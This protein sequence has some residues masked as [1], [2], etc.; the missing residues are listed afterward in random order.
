MIF[1]L[2]SSSVPPKETHRQPLTL[3]LIFTSPGARPALCLGKWSAGATSGLTISPLPDSVP[4]RALLAMSTGPICST[5][6][7][8][9]QQ[10]AE[11]IEDEARTLVTL[12]FA[13]FSDSTVSTWLLSLKLFFST[14]K[15]SFFLP[16][17]PNLWGSTHTLQLLW[18]LVWLIQSSVNSCYTE[19]HLLELQYKNVLLIN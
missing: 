2:L 12:C 4:W 14:G 11:L 18:H 9:V 15:P 13:H 10:S 1:Q 19:L 17:D 8:P 6:L 3:L 5:V 7:E 16:T